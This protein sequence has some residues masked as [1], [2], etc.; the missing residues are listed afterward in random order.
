MPAL[1]LAL[2]PIFGVSQEKAADLIPDTEIVALQD[3]LAQGSRGATSV[4]VRPV[5]ASVSSEI[6]LAFPSRPSL[7]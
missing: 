2:V 7:R 4:D 6:K 3:E 1:L 5:L